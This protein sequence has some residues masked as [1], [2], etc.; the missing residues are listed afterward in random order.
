MSLD[1][2]TQ[3]LPCIS[4]LPTA[5]VAASLAALVLQHSDLAGKAPPFWISWTEGQNKDTFNIKA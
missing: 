1:V 3:N 2:Y 5:A 4:E